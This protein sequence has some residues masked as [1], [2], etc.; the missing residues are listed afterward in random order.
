VLI[1]QHAAHE[2]VA[3]QRLRE[4]ADQ[5]E[6]P[7]QALL[8]PQIVE[9][10]AVEAALAA[11]AGPLLA[12]VGFDVEPFGGTAIAVKA[13]PAGLRQEPTQVLRELL[14]ELVEHGGSRAV[15]AR[16]EH[17]LA[18]VACHSVVRA[19]DPLTGDEVRAL[20]AQMDTV[21]FRTHCPHGRPV[22]VRVGVAEIGRR[23]G[24]T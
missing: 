23:F 14:A 1:D 20:F 19:G 24:R 11:D 4:R 18:T 3:F 6:V 9:L 21:D 15:E 13:V 12:R 16:L 10:P 5:G 17:V 8:F 2:R 7:V 22:M